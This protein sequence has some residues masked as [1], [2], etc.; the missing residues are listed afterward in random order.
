MNGISMNN[1][2][3]PVTALRRAREKKRELDTRFLEFANKRKPDPALPVLGIVK[4]RTG[5]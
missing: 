2:I 5:R 1:K 4:G 3:E